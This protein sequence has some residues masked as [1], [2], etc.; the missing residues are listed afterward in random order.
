M[1]LPPFPTPSRWQEVGAIQLYY[2]ESFWSTGR[3]TSVPSGVTT[4]DNDIY[5]THYVQTTIGGNGRV[6]DII[7]AANVQS[8]TVLTSVGLIVPTDEVIDGATISGGDDAVLEEVLTLNDF[9]TTRLSK[10]MSKMKKKRHIARRRMMR[11]ERKAVKSTHP[12]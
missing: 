4:T 6:D 3:M 1:I 8:G 2:D 7:V 10:T 12:M 5:A 11:K 9:W